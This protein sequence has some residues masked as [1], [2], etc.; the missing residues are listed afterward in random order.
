VCGAGPEWRARKLIVESELGP[1]NS[2]SVQ[3]FLSLNI[4]ELTDIFVNCNVQYPW[5]LR[6]VH[7]KLLTNPFALH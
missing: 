7:T 1:L 5:Q 6:V 3:A 4:L 2:F